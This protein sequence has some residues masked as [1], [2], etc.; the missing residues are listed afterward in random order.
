[1][2][3]SKE[4]LYLNY[5]PLWMVSKEEVML[6]SLLPPTDLMLL[7]PLSEDSVDLI[8]KSI[9]EFL[10]KSVDSKY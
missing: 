9:L 6:L 4:E 10:I 2:V 3:K 8:D 7:I 1:M 5:L